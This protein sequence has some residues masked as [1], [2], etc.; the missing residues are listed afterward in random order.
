MIQELNFT[1][2]QAVIF[3]IVLAV[4]FYFVITAKSQAPTAQI[5]S[6]REPVEEQ[7]DNYNYTNLTYLERYGAY[8]QAQNHYYN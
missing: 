6:D 5:E 8:I 7:E 3:L 2:T 1:P 4:L